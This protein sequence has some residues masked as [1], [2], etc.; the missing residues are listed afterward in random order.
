[1]ISNSNNVQSKFN[2]LNKKMISCKNKLEPMYNRLLKTKSPTKENLLK[3]F[4]LFISKKEIKDLKTYMDDM[5][6][7][8]KDP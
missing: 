5:D 4:F 8:F 6:R 2:E 1:L 3:Y 7:K